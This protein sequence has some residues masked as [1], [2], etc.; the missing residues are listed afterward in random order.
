MLEG[1]LSA[2]PFFPEQLVQPETPLLQ[3]S[4]DC[5]SCV[6]YAIRLFQM[7][8]WS[9]LTKLPVVPPLHAYFDLFGFYIKRQSQIRSR[10]ERNLNRLQNACPSLFQCVAVR[11]TAWQRRTL[12]YE[13]AV[14]VQRV[15]DYK[16]HRYLFYPASRNLVKTQTKGQF[17]IT[18]TIY[19]FNHTSAVLQRMK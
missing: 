1:Y 15:C 17:R 8:L 13:T 19:R 4:Y 9:F 2:S 3:A 12:G 14:F 11:H 5:L 6:Q 18:S 10:F 7:F 16:L